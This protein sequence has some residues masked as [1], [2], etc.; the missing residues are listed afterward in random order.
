MFTFNFIELLRLPLPQDHIF[1][2]E[3]LGS[4]SSFYSRE[5]SAS[6]SAFSLSKVPINC[7]LK[8]LSSFES[9]LEGLYVVLV[10][11]VEETGAAAASVSDV[12]DLY[13]GY[14]FMTLPSKSGLLT[15]NINSFILAVQLKF[16]AAASTAANATFVGVAVELRSTAEEAAGFFGEFVPLDSTAVAAP[17]PYL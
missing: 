14:H 4:C 6:I 12:E 3:G 10:N 2:A 1:F 11:V 13:T 16:L 17:E 7:F 5:N 9:F 8:S 15:L